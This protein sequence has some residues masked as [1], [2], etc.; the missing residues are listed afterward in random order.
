MPYC[1]RMRLRRRI[2]VT[3]DRQEISITS[4]GA[5]RREGY[6]ERC[7]RAV[8]ML[9]VAMAAGLSG[10]SERVLYQWVESGNAH[11]TERP[12]GEV[13]ICAK[14]LVEQK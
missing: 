7:G 3:V 8:P 13:L 4:R 10:I 12:N 11:F 5:V 2:S 14:S 6:C 9:P 1:R